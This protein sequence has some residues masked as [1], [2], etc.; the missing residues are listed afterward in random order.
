MYGEQYKVGGR[1]GWRCPGECSPIS[2][3]DSMKTMFMDVHVE[4]K[5]RNGI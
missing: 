5:T 4:E 3:L 2:V 1:H